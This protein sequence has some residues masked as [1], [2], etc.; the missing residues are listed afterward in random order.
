MTIGTP[1][2]LNARAPPGSMGL[3]PVRY[4]VTVLMPKVS[5]VELYWVLPCATETPRV[6]R[7]EAPNWYGHQT[8]GWLIVSAGKSLGA[9][10]TVWVVLAGTVTL[11]LTAIGLAPLPG[12]VTVAV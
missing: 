10:D 7:G 12:G 5:A 1:L 3:D 6:Y 8:C 11:C 4:D 9:K 2:I